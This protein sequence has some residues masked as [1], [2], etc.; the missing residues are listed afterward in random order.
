MK[1][2]LF[3]ILAFCSAVALAQYP[4]IDVGA[5]NGASEQTLSY[6]VD[7]AGA[8]HLFIAIKAL[9]PYHEGNITARTRM[10]HYYSND[11]GKTWAGI[12]T[13]YPSSANTNDPTCAFDIANHEA[14]FSDNANVVRY[15]NWG[16][17]STPFTHQ[18][19][20]AFTHGA[21]NPTV[22]VDNSPLSRYRGN[23]YELWSG[24]TIANGVSYPVIFFSYSQNQGGSWSS[25]PTYSFSNGEPCAMAVDGY[26]N[27]YA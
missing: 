13:M 23:M 10:G 5:N 27:I 8:A 22:I 21:D 14:F 15:N 26:G 17:S 9:K 19:D 1:H 7:S 24:S 16:Q 20:T 18:Y 4:N 3:S 2:I 25:P 6:A 11:G 12:D